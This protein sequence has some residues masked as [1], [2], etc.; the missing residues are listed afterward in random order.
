MKTK[1]KSLTISFVT[2]DCGMIVADRLS[3][4]VFLFI[5]LFVAAFHHTHN[6]DTVQEWACKPPSEFFSTD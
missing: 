5:Y 1:Q 2:V 6:R 4:L 3:C